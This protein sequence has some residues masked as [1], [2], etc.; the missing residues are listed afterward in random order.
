MK[1]SLSVPDYQ[2]LAELRYQIRRFLHFSEQVVRGAGLEPRQ[3]QLLLAVKGL[4]PGV[5][6]R[7]AELAER[8]QIQHHSAVEL[9]NR[10]AAGGY[11]RRQRG[12]NDRREVLLTLTPKG[13]K[14]LQEMAL[15]HWEELRSAGPALTAALSRVVRRISSNKGK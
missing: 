2:S 14:V 15:H 11:I 6:P 7:I 3:H 10:L 4:P 13:E 5:R 1:R 9:T 8:L 12:G